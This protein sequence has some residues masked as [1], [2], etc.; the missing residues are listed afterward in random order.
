MMVNLSLFSALR[1]CQ[2]ISNAV[3]SVIITSHQWSRANTHL[4]KQVLGTIWCDSGWS[5]S[6]SSPISSREPQS[7]S[8]PNVLAQGLQVKE[9][10]THLFDHCFQ[11]PLGTHQGNGSYY[12]G[13]E[14]PEGPV[15]QAYKREERSSQA[16]KGKLQS[17]TKSL[18]TDFQHSNQRA[19]PF[20]WPKTR[21]TYT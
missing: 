8:L 11:P 6:E 5:P 19:S 9:Q 17:D 2:E 10:Q 21:S 3:H 7:S 13:M 4:S 20:A 15:L 12:F 1:T 18:L 16:R 14:H